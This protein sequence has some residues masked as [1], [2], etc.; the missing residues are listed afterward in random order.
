[1]F[2]AASEFE[3]AARTLP[4]HPD[5][6]LNLALTLERAGRIDDAIDEYQSALEIY[7]G[8][9][10]TIQAMTRCRLRNQP[11][12]AQDDP[13]TASGLREVA[14]RGTTTEWREWAQRQ[15]TL[16]DK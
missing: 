10:Q 2:S 13:T 12:E 7:P 6:R 1:M 14:L 15:L 8:H 4:G 3:W 9:I 16:R 11:K 5:P